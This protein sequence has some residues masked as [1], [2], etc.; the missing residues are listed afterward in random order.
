MGTQ[1]L[2]QEPLKTSRA[3]ERPPTVLVVEDDQCLLKLLTDLLTDERYYVLRAAS[4]RQALRVV[5][6]A[7]ELPQLF[8]FDYNLGETTGLELYDYLHARAGFKDIPAILVS[9][10]LPEQDELDRRSIVG[11][12]K[13]Y[14]IDVLLERVA[15]VMSNNHVRRRS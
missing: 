7:E 1:C 11:M 13:P 8:L 3:V 15:A 6:Q 9:A 10:D 5:A 14:D 12:R 2:L 4:A